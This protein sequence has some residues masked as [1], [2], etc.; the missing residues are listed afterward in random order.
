MELLAK[1]SAF[2]VANPCVRK[3]ILRGFCNASS[4]NP[5]YG[6]GSRT[7]ATLNTSN[8]AV[9][10]F[11]TWP[12]ESRRRHVQVRLT[13]CSHLPYHVLY[14]WMSYIAFMFIGLQNCCTCILPSIHPYPI[15]P[16]EKNSRLDVPLC[17]FKKTQ[18]TPTEYSIFQKTV[19]LLKLLQTLMGCYPIA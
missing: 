7:L 17:I 15:F 3:A 9:L 4:M 1:P 16:P 13:V 2:V 11:T 10:N 19:I 8:Q 12:M 18:R 6:Y 14:Q 5:G